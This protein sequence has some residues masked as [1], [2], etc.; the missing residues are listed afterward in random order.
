MTTA[1]RPELTDNLHQARKLIATTPSE[2]QREVATTLALIDI[3]ESLRDL[4]AWC[5]NG[6]FGR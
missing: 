6:G 2:R 5:N 4:A 3:A 1:E